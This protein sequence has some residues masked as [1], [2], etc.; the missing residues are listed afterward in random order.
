M[1]SHNP[2]HNYVYKFL[3]RRWI[4]GGGD[5]HSPNQVYIVFKSTN[6]G[7]QSPCG[8]IRIQI[9]GR[10]FD[11]ISGSSILL[12]KFLLC[13][14]QRTKIMASL[15]FSIEVLDDPKRINSH[16]CTLL[17]TKNINLLK[18]PGMNVNVK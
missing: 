3:G 13:S 15:P 10:T 14:S 16:G 18:H 4:Y 17:L 12:T 11:N 5:M 7:Q 8:Q 1:I 6:Q 2:C 9:P